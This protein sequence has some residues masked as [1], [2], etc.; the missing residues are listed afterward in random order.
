M[1]V[2]VGFAPNRPPAD[3]EPDVSLAGLV[4][5]RPPPLGAGVESDFCP[6]SP[7]ADD[8]CPPNRPKV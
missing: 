6:K 4:L 7:P 3:A 8:C 1:L 5:K 2:A